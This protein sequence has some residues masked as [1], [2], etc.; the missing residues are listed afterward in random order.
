MSLPASR[1]DRYR[2]I[3]GRARKIPGQH[4]IR[5]YSVAIVIGAWAGPY[6]GRS[7][8]TETLS[9][10]TERDGF[11]PKVRFLNEE[12]RTL[13]GLADGA[14]TVGPITPDNSSGGTP[15]ASLARAVA[16]QQE[17]HVKITG[18]AYPAGALFAV[19]EVKTDHA[20]HWT[21]VCVPSEQLT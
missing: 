18:P 1:L 16:A 15:L 14:C 10:I 20:L 8:K 2:R 13:A 11:P 3:A 5:P 6:V 7:G 19:K 9:A 4:G 12:Q 17:A 21:L